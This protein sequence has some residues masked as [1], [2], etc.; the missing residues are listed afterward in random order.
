MS[1]IINLALE[2]SRKE[3]PHARM[4]IELWRL[5]DGTVRYHAHVEDRVGFSRGWLRDNLRWALLVYSKHWRMGLRWPQR[6]KRRS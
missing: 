6:R 4:V 2:R 1:E 5:E 3:E